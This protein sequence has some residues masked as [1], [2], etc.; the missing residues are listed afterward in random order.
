[1]GMEQT[2]LRPVIAAS[3]Q[4]ARV[5]G[6]DPGMPVHS[7][8]LGEVD[9]DSRLLRAAAPV[10]DEI[11]AALRDTDFVTV[12]A[13]R[14]L[15][16]VD[17]RSGDTATRNRLERLGLI[18]GRRLE[19]NVIGTNSL[20]TAV[21]V[22]AGVAVH[23]GEHYI[24][25]LKQFSCYG[26][27]IVHPATR[28]LEGVLDITC[29]AAESS[30]LLAPFIR[31]AVSRI[32]ERLVSD[33]RITE[34]QLLSAFQSTLVQDRGAAV[35]AVGGDLF[36]AN[37]AAIDLLEPADHAV[38]R[39]IAGAS[40]R[41]GDRMSVRLSSGRD[42][43]TVVRQVAGGALFVFDRSPIAPPSGNR[44]ADGHV[45][46]CGDCGSGRT[47]TV[48]DLVGSAARVAWFD[49]ADSAL[50][51]HAEWP[52]QVAAGLSTADVVVVE[53]IHLLTAPLARALASALDTSRA[54]AILTSSH[55]D[56][57]DVEQSSLIARCVHRID[58]APLR[59]RPQEIPGLVLA[60]TADLGAPRELRWTAAALET[61]AGQPLPGNLT[62]LRAVV[63]HVVNTR[64]VGDVTV[65]DL[66]ERYR[67]RAQKLTPIERAEH[68]A[69]VDALHAAG[70]NKLMA[71][72]RL[73]ISRT[74]LYRSI[75]RYGIVPPVS[76][77]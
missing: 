52:A 75:R 48:R 65:R 59:S 11:G 24:E 47:R 8:G 70:G 15:R 58:L 40:S 56:H 55:A 9:P 50:P 60:M 18:A 46:V 20:A 7:A 35:A 44:L 12:L 67:S 22:G 63:R 3:W 33:T 53:A 16:L 10:L 28:R 77:K 5:A 51:R 30:P 17:L 76:T 36:V 1:M 66:P 2:P 54:R 25:E 74:T 38:L 29:A 57:L 14:D 37:N 43:G 26:H 71:A 68:D 4:R 6:L 49:A 69:I 39:G 27:P 72:A 64:R 21:E 13:D 73:G 42:V 62:E 31:S 34:R 41:V 23:G 61:L 45:A 32:E 19:E